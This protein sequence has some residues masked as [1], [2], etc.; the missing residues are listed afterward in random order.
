MSVP[1]VIFIDTSVF[2]EQNYNFASSSLSSFI[3]AITGKSFVLLLPDPIQREVNRHIKERSNGAIKAL[4]DARRKAPFLSKWKA[5]PLGSKEDRPMLSREL[6]NIAK[7]EW[8]G[9]LELF[10]VKKLSYDG[11]NLQE[12]MNWYDKVRAP[13]GEGKK[14]KEFPDAFAI[15]AILEFAKTNNTSIAVISKDKGIKKACEAYTKFL[16]FKSLPA[17]TEAILSGEEKLKIAKKLLKSAKK[18][19]CDAISNSFYNLKFYLVSDM[20]GEIG[21]VEVNNVQLEDLSVIG[22]GEFECTVAFEA[23][24]DFHVSFECYDPYGTYHPER[25]SVEES[26]YLSGAMKIELNEN[27]DKVQEIYVME[28]G[29]SVVTIEWEPY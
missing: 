5:W 8:E 19:I 14:R 13:F 17:F 23:Y 20:H 10:N 1:N 21:E 9:F 24:I 28:I 2:D 26:K 27:W 11:I 29:D 22:L 18:D 6:H 15:A 3:S 16:Y 7:K 12:I 25:V 4:E